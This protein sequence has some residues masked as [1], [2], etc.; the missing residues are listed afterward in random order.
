MG[1]SSGRLL[2]TLLLTVCAALP[3]AGQRAQNH[4][5]LLLLDPGHTPQMP[6]ARSSQGL[7]ER[8][9]NQ[10]IARLL[11]ERLGKD[12]DIEVKSTNGPEESIGLLDRVKMAAALKADLFLSLHH[13]SVQPAHLHPWEFNGDKLKYCDDFKGFSIHA[14]T[15]QSKPVAEKSYRFAKIAANKMIQQGFPF[16]LHHEEKIEGEDMK[17]LDRSLGIY[18]RNHLAVLRANKSPAVLIECGVIVNR[19]EDRRLQDPAVQAQI[20]EALYQAVREYK[21]Q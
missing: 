17:L 14:A 10:T 8:E 12:G 16:T 6:G 20:V 3:A 11:M 5:F 4:K 13:D 18:E 21:D 1:L 2:R 15:V 9:Y 19:D 7:Y